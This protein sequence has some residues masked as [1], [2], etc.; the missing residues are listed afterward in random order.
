MNEEEIIKD[1]K[2]VKDEIIITITLK[3]RKYSIEPWIIFDKTKIVDLIPDKYKGKVSLISA[4]DKIVSNLRN[5]PNK[6]VNPGVWRFKINKATRSRKTTKPQKPL[7]K[8]DNT[9]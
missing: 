8:K 5:S 1:V 9:K 4:P 3:Y 7:D 2:I 6:Y